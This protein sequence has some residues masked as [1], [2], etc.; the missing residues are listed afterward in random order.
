MP[1]DVKFYELS[2]EAD[3]D[4]SDIFDYTER[5]FGLDQAVAYVSAF[6]EC[7][8][9]LLENPQLGRERQEILK[10]LRSISHEAHVVFYRVL[11]DRIRIV[12]VLHGS[13]DL[14]RHFQR[15]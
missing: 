8:S 7:F 3:Q 2:I 13:R 14:P 12:R 15:I 5:E 1:H 9:Q 11:I 4:I 6:D 10:E